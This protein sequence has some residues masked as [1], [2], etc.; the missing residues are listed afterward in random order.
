MKIT[1]E[2]NDTE[3]DRDAVINCIKYLRK[4]FELDGMLIYLFDISGCSKNGIEIESTFYAKNSSE[5][6]LAIKSFFAGFRYA[7]DRFNRSCQKVI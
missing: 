7:E 4:L 2:N 1:I 3:F 5:I 6:D